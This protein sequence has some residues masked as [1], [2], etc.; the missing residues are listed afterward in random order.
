VFSDSGIPKGKLMV[1]RSRCKL[2]DNGN[3]MEANYSTIRNLFIEGGGGKAEAIVNYRF[4][5]TPN[6]T[7]LEPK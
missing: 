6:D 4:N 5:P 2:D 3:I 1:V 7:N